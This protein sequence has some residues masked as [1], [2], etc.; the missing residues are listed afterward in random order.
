MAGS[1]LA[2]TCVFLL[3]CGAAVALGSWQWGRLNPPGINNGNH[4][5]IRMPSPTE[6]RLL[7]REFAETTGLD[8]AL[9]A[10]LSKKFEEDPRAAARQALSVMTADQLSS[11]GQ[12]MAARWREREQ[13]LAKM[14]SPED[15]RA[16]RE[17]WPGGG[18]PGWMRMRGFGPAP[19]PSN[20]GR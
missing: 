8:R 17:R 16:L 2:K 18:R 13:R 7:E 10:E 19:A 11:A 3:L 5:N 6:R 4:S 9:V 15:M 20:S 12:F 14:L 1:K